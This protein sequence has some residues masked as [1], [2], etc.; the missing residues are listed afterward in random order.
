VI[1]IR[2]FRRLP[3]AGI[4]RA[5]LVLLAILIASTRFASNAQA[6][7]GGWDY[8]PD[9]IHA[10]L[11]IDVPG[12]LAEQWTVELPEYLER[13]VATALAPVWEFDIK[14]AAGAE[15]AQVLN[16]LRAAE[17][18]KPSDMPKEKDKLL[19]LFVQSQADGFKLCA[20]E[21]DQ[22]IERWGAVIERECRQT[23]TVPE[24]LFTLAWQTVSPLAQ[25]EFDA[26]ENRL[27]LKPRGGALPRS[28][29]APPWAKPGDVFLPLVRRTSRT[30]QILEK[31]G[32]SAIPWTYV[33][34]VEVK[35]KPL[36]YHFQSGSRRPFMARRQSR[37]EQLAV[38]VRTDSA[39]TT[40]RL[41]ARKDEKKPLVGYEV[42]AQ[43]AGVETPT[44][45]GL[46]DN[47]GRVIVPPGKSH[48]E[49]LL[50][51]HGGQ[52]LA[53]LP[54]VPGATSTI[55]VPLPDD[56]AR[57]A[58][59][60]RLAAIREDLIDVVARRN[61]L[62][63]RVR[64]KI[65]KQDYKGAQELLQTLD[66]LQGKPQFNL[67]LTEAARQLRSN[68]PMMQRRIDQ[69]FQQTQTLTSK[70]LDLKPINEI[71]NE[72]REAQQAPKTPAKEGKT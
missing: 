67:K 53:K 32:I 55:N 43:T 50:V 29:E 3:Q 27:T 72:F 57:L 24:Q 58:A 9:R 19:L 61:I 62:I 60:A 39:P 33:E 40:L 20:R 51:K 31:G 42:L 5:A 28:A 49:M 37:V 34:A 12:G 48:I 11:V 69:L 47:A 6:A 52:L 22:Y 15:R 68:D 56:D 10:L 54:V 63:A 66:D 71:H 45:V 18:A 46:S 65:K 59:E 21:Y 16:N 38:G 2:A 70:F 26:K 35:D 4:V 7:M 13:R 17:P 8:Q 23:S 14:L 36:E 30:G 44:Q 41:H 64:Q 1:T 25:L